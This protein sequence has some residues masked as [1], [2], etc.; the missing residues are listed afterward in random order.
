MTVMLVSFA[1]S[2]TGSGERNSWAPSQ[3]SSQLRR[4]KELPIRH[5]GPIL[6]RSLLWK[7]CTLADSGF[8]KNFL[9]QGGVKSTISWVFEDRKF[10]IS[11]G[12]DQNWCFPDS[13]QLAVSAK[14]RR[15]NFLLS[16]DR[17]L[18]HLVEKWKKIIKFGKKSWIV[19]NIHFS[20]RNLAGS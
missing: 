18:N 2:P 13:A 5:S 1:G 9:Y 12:C 15:R 3:G 11:E 16:K 14:L 19:V 17:Y 7:V 20:L 6:Y 8:L 10:K 4:E